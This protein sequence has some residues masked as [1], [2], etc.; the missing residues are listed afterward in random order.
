M[1]CPGQLGSP[2]VDEPTL[3]AASAKR[4]ARGWF[5]GIILKDRNESILR[6]GSIRVT[7]RTGTVGF[8]RRSHS[9]YG[10]FL[11][12]SARTGLISKVGL[13]SSPAV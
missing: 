5:K 10:S 3:A 4:L 8:A 1:R 7:A 12:F 11:A 6:N 13:G 2:R 9:D